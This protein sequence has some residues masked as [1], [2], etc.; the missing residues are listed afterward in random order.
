MKAHFPK[1]GRLDG[2]VTKYTFNRA[3]EDRKFYTARKE[4]Y[5]E[6]KE[7]ISS[8]KNFNTTIFLIE[9]EDGSVLSP[10]R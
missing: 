3:E 4:I 10:V 8:L 6:K 9:D 7:H 5:G 2:Y 1:R